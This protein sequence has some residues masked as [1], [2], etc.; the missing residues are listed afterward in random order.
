MT[1]EGGKMG[2]AHDSKNCRSGRMARVA[3]N[4]RRAGVS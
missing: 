3:A 1:E 4:I 2:F